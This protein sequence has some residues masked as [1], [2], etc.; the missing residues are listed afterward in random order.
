M[1]I[2]IRIITIAMRI[3]HIG[4][5]DAGIEENSPNPDLKISAY[6]SIPTRTL[7][8]SREE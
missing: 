1:M 4:V 2:I 3:I 5:V 7:G 8:N 6:L